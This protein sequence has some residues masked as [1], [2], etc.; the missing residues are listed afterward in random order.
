MKRVFEVVAT[1]DHGL[2]FLQFPG[3]TEFV[4][5]A[6]NVANIEEMAKDLIF[7]ETNTPLEDIELKVTVMPMELSTP[8]A[9]S[10]M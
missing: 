4:S 9:I 3:T 1:P 7:M 6:V 8:A 2:W 10:H 5:T